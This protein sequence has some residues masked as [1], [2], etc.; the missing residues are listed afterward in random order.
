MPTIWHP[1]DFTPTPLALAGRK[2]S[3]ETQTDGHHT[4]LITLRR[5]YR[6][7]RN[8]PRIK[9]HIQYSTHKAPVAENLHVDH[10]PRLSVLCA[11]RIAPDTQQHQFKPKN[12]KKRPKPLFSSKHLNK[13]TGYSAAGTFDAGLFV[14]CLNQPRGRQSTSG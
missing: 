7:Q 8:T 4:R 5:V 6:A 1:A 10:N 12:R 9:R 2:R 13:I 14:C 3:V 11:L